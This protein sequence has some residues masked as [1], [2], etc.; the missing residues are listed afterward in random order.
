MISFHVFIP[1]RRVRFGDQLQVQFW[2]MIYFAHN[3]CLR[4]HRRCELDFFHKLFHISRFR[5]ADQTIFLHP[6]HGNSTGHILEFAIRL[7]PLEPATYF[8]GELCPGEFR[9]VRYERSD[10]FKFFERKIPS[11]VSDH[12]V[13][14]GLVSINRRSSLISQGRKGDRSSGALP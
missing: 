13:S 1:Q 7:Q 6:Q 5:Q 2:Q 9:I 4:I 3:L 8:S 11:T 10:F 14:G 12:D